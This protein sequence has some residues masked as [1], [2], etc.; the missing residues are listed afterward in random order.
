MADLG[1]STNSILVGLFL[2]MF[3][4]LTYYLA[5]LA[6]LNGKFGI[7]FFVMNFLLTSLTIGLVTLSVIAMKSS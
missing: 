2:L 6:I 5:P 3:G 7:F 4:F 1:M